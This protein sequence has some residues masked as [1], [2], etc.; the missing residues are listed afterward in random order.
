MLRL[1]IPLTQALETF[2]FF[3][4]NLLA[5]ARDAPTNH[6]SK[7]VQRR[8]TQANEVADAVLLGIAHSYDRI[9]TLL[10]TAYSGAEHG[11]K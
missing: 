9:S 5:A 7:E 4:N 1:Q 11:Q 6:P 10:P 2:A 8:Y 3:R